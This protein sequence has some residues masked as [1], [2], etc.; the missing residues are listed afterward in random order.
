[1]TII[2]AN[3]MKELKL[4]ELITIQMGRKVKMKRW[5]ISSRTSLGSRR[6]KKEGSKHELKKKMKDYSQRTQ[7]S[8]E[9]RHTKYDCPRSKKNESSSKKAFVATWNDGEDSTDNG[10]AH[11]CLMAF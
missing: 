4:G 11:L 2:E 5:Y 6:T 10:V 9:K 1:M 3:N 8:K 7:I